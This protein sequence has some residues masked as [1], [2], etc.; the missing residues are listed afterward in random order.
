MNTLTNINTKETWTG[1]KAE[2]QFKSGQIKFDF[3]ITAPYI[4]DGIY[5]KITKQST[6]SKYITVLDY[7]EC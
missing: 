2:F 4:L 6:D 1:T 7:T 5:I 3:D